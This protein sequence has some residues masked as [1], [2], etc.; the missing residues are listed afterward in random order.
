MGL[1]GCTPNN[2]APLRDA[3]YT[4]TM[5]QVFREMAV[6]VTWPNDMNKKMLLV[7]DMGGHPEH[8]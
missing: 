3:S 1:H 8:A 4:S 7:E 5:F 2:F 6:N